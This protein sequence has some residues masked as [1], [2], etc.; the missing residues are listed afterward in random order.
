MTATAT[1]IEFGTDGWRALIA[2]DFTFAN[3]RLCA[4]AVA[5]YLRDQRLAERAPLR[6][7]REPHELREGRR[8]VGYVHRPL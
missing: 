2:Q 5:D 3:V 1:R 8:E 6:P 7:V 4:K